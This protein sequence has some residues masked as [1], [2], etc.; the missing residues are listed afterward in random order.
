[1]N[2]QGHLIE[3]YDRSERVNHW[4]VA[5]S[6]VLAGLSGLALFHPSMFWLSSLFGGGTWTRV[7]HPFI[8]VFMV[9]FFV[10][11]AARFWGQNRLT[12]ADR[13]WMRQL[14]DVMMDREER[15]PEVGRYNAGQKIVFW[16]MVISIAVLL[17][18]GIMIWQPYFAPVFSNGMRSFA[19]ALHAFAAFVALLTL[20]IHVYAAI[21]VKGSVRAMTRGTVSTAWAKQH[22]P[23][24]YRGSRE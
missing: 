22:H 11:L 17:I 23:A 19:T 24:W 18:S 6:F 5:I 13:Q 10:W 1:M 2:R 12:D 16:I 7:L 4:I 15:L 14:D 20:I 21:W 9:I 3:R 8:A